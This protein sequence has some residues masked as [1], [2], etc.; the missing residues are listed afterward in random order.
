M[1]RHFLVGRGI[2]H[3]KS[4]A[5][6]NALYDRLGLDWRYDLEDVGSEQDAKRLIEAG[7]WLSAN[8]TTPYK[9][10]AA[11]CAQV[12]A[13]SVQLAGGANLLIARNGAVVGLNTDGRG[14]VRHIQ[15]AGHGL[16]G[17][18]VVVCGTGPTSLAIFL[19]AAQAGADRVALIGRDRDR[20]KAVL[21]GFVA[22]WK[23]LA[24][25]TVELSSP[26][27]GERSFREA[28]EACSFVFGTYETSTNEIA[29]ATVVVDAT[30]L[31][32]QPGDPL[33]FAEELLGGQEL[34][35]DVVY[36]HGGSRLLDAA[37]QAG[38]AVLDGRGMVVAQA[39]EN[40]RVVID[41]HGVDAGMDWDEMFQ[42]M[43]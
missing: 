29:G 13:A 26:D 34:V 40:A 38:C 18:R 14:C 8:A 3:S 30:P 12:K 7:G 10:L 43:E 28:F 2:A 39:V 23:E 36:G 37:E 42:L 41:A 11:R 32:M 17:A 33:P 35:Y 20:T 22:R 24:Y 9:Q 16:E 4:P 27:S 5:M 25:A 19:A 15:R 31:G 21:E 1:E 6:Y